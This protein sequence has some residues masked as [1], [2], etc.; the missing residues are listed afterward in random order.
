MRREFPV[1]KSSYYLWSLR[2]A[3][4]FLGVL[5][6][7]PAFG[8]D[9]T[10]SVQ[11]ALKGTWKSVCMNLGSGVFI[12]ITSTYDG[13]GHA[14]DKVV[15]YSDAGCGAPTGLVKSNSSVSYSVGA[16]IQV[17]S[18][19]AHAINSTIQSW[20]LTQNGSVIKSGGAV[21]TQY[22]IFAIEGNKLY[23]S[24]LTRG[25]SGPITSAAG[26]PTTLDTTNYF[27]KQ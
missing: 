26:R 13:A 17:G 4:M 8:Q 1:K 16:P 24:G 22:D 20:Q 3:L 14:S 2:A 10:D 18:R 23:T 11:A 21:A 7:A 12:T 25:Q 19:Q 9:S 5:V 6:A 27:T 15:Y